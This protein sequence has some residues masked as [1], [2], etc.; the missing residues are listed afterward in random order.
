MKTEDPNATVHDYR[1]FLN[2]FCGSSIYTSDEDPLCHKPLSHHFDAS[3]L[4]DTDYLY[5]PG[6]RQEQSI[7]RMNTFPPFALYIVSTICVAVGLFCTICSLE[8][9]TWL[10]IP[11]IQIVAIVSNTVGLCSDAAASVYITLFVIKMQ[12]SLL[13]LRDRAESG[14]SAGPMIQDVELGAPFLLLSW[15]RVGAVSIVMMLTIVHRRA[16]TLSRGVDNESPQVE[17]MYVDMGQ[18]KQDLQDDFLPRY[19]EDDGLPLYRLT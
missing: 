10:D 12:Q 17:P 19:C 3:T 18:V 15:A 11:N 16:S 8:T 14:G 13:A 2:A 4:I 9:V 5:P 1:Y 7:L 6:Q